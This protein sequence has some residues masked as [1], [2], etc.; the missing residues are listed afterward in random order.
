MRP[1]KFANRVYD[2]PE[3]PSLKGS[4]CSMVDSPPDA[5]EKGRRGDEPNL[6][7]SSPSSEASQQAACSNDDTGS[8]R[9]KFGEGTAR[10]SGFINEN[11]IAVRYGVIASISVLGCYAISQ[12]PLFFRYRTVSEI[13]PPFF[14][15][16]KCMTGR[17]MIC[18]NTNSSN[19][20]SAVR[21]Q[22]EP[23][24]CYLR[25]LS[26][27]ERLLP[28]SWLDRLLKL[29]PAASFSKGKPEESPHELIRIQIAGI[30][31]PTTRNSNKSNISSSSVRQLISIN[32][33]SNHDLSA[34][35]DW[36]NKLAEQRSLV[37][38][39]LLARRI[40]N[41]GASSKQEHSSRSK[42]PIPGL[43]SDSVFDASIKDKGEHVAVARLFYRPKPT[44]LFRTDLGESMVL[45]G[46]AAV[47]D[48][49]LYPHSPAERVVDA[50]E[51]VKSLQRD[52]GYMERLGRAEYQAARGSYG[53]W[54]DPEYRQE[55]ADVMDEVYFQEKAS[56]F[57]KAWR[58]LRG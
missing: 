35:Q 39:Q 27:M 5:Q 32:Y 44:Q 34:G 41:S 28:K 1:W 22:F 30:Q 25:H 24:T 26:P 48:D 55:R 15:R 57:R 38:C 12:T 51:Q 2:R 45:K 52:A 19:H 42:R 13:P 37:R 31:Y 46:Y 47:S 3:R 18:N 53:V 11:K 54:A 21:G 49:G 4:E 43:P 56:V 23:I 17:L 29:Y 20:T 36:I 9:S 6:A 10:F 7:V 40:P 58:W 16:R 8:L 33:E 50:T 14:H